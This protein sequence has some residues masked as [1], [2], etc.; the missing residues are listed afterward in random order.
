MQHGDNGS[1]MG[2]IQSSGDYTGIMGMIIMILT[3]FEM[4]MGQ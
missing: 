2:N 4:I 3:I 1:T